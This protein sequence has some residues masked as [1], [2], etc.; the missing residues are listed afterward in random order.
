MIFSNVLMKKKQLPI[1]I[2]AEAGVNH[3]GSLQTA[4][5]LIDEAKGAGAD[6]VKFQSFKAEKLASKSAEMASYQKNN[7][8]KQESQLTM[9]K[10][11]ELS[12][13][14]HLDLMR[15]AKKRRIAFISS[16]FDEES[17]DL[18]EEME[19]SMYK[20]PSGEITNL[21]YIFHVARKGKPLIISTGM[22]NLEEIREVV[23]T[24][25]AAGNKN[26]TLL[27]CVTEYPAPYNE[28]NL[29][30]MGTMWKVFRLPVGYSDH[31]EGIEIA[32]AAAAMGAAVIEKHFTISR[33]MPGPD[34]A[35]SIE[36][37]ELR[38]MISA[39][40]HVELARGDGKKIPAPC[41]KKNIA[42]ARKSVVANRLIKKGHAI[43]S[44]DISIK[45][46]GNGIP[47]KQIAQVVGK[48]A[49][50]TIK[51]GPILWNMIR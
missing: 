10:R 34:H 13:E 32:I 1:F 16:P 4:K 36:P 5:K 8:G 25:Y 14:A 42:V 11:L 15:H 31:T 3:N 27:H 47:P 28:I 33:D 38:E 7:S 41:E 45:R 46:P 19:V 2:I 44:E 35:A 6:A 21:A 49:K 23:E 29:S 20:I 22:A 50:K 17:A 37:N 12:R 9:L 24:C 51:E 39:I 43:L 30:A 26:I 18:L 48:R 40:R